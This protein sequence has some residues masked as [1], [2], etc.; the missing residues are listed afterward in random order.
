[1]PVIDKDAVPHTSETIDT[2]IEMPVIDKDAVPHTSETVDEFVETPII[3]TNAPTREAVDEFVETSVINTDTPPTSQTSEAYAP[4]E[5]FV[6]NVN[7]NVFEV[8]DN[9][10][11]LSETKPRYMIDKIHDILGVN[12][13]KKDFKDPGKKKKLK[14]FL[15]LK[16]S[17]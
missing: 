11:S 10:I 15:L 6:Q 5:T 4:N 13:Y 2:F 3:D 16:S 17:H 7:D 14:R 8:S 12:M 1:M 9:K